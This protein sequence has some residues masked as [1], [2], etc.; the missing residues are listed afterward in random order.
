MQ[1]DA[2]GVPY[3]AAQADFT[4][5][6]FRR[7]DGDVNQDGQQGYQLSQVETIY[8]RILHKN[9]SVCGGGGDLF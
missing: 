4:C 3:L 2:T 1:V 9:V 8:G 5:D 7:L 6:T